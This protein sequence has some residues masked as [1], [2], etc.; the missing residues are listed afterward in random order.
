LEEALVVEIV[1]HLLQVLGLVVA[2]LVD[3]ELRQDFP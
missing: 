3:I 1:G 2:A